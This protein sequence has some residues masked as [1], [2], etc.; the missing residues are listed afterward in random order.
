MQKKILSNKIKDSRFHP[1]EFTT[2]L[3]PVYGVE[4]NRM[5]ALVICL[6]GQ[7]QNIDL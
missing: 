6:G 3:Q 5:L 7:I 2:C 1:N 4:F